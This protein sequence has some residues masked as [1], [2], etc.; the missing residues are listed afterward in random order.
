MNIVLS[1]NIAHFPFN[2]YVVTTSHF[3]DKDGFS[4]YFHI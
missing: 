3:V 2:I 1:F 4:G